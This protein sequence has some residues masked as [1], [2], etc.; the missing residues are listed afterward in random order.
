[1]VVRM[2]FYIEIAMRFKICID[3]KV[4]VRF[5]VLN[6]LSKREEGGLNCKSG[7]QYCNKLK[8]KKY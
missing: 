2:P 3:L 4:I 7:L 1:M 8:I 5:I 6:L